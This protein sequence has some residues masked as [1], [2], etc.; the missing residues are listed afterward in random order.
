MTPQQ[1]LDY[2]VAAAY[3]NQYSQAAAAYEQFAMSPANTAAYGVLP[4]AYANAY[5]PAGSAALT[6]A[7]QAQ[8][9]AADAGRLQQ[10]HMS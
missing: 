6:S 4:A 1:L 2:Q 10:V 3:A 7:Y 9:A 8:T 5:G